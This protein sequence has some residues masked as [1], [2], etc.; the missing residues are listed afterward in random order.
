MHLTRLLAVSDINVEDGKVEQENFD[1]YE[2]MKIK[3]MPKVEVTV[4]PSGGFWGGAGE[5]TICV[6]APAVL[7]AITAAT[8]KRYRTS[9][10]RDNGVK[11]WVVARATAQLDKAHG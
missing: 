1:S 8:G 7:N 6:A 5:P 10:L 11:L 4:M 9:P 2:M 3:D